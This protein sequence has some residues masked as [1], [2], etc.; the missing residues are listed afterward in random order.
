MINETIFIDKLCKSFTKDRPLLSNVTIK[1]HSGE[2]LGI[3]GPS[4]SGKSTLLRTI[5]GL[6]KVDSGKIFLDGNDITNIEVDKRGI[7]MVFQNFALF[8]HKNVYKNISFGLEIMNI[9][10]TEIKERVESLL[11]LVNLQDFEKREIHNLSG[12]E[13]QRVAIARSL[14]TTPKVLLMDEPFSALDNAVKIKLV[15]DIKRIVKKLKLSMIVVSHDQM[16]IQKLCDTSM[17]L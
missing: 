12:G 10:K 15:D 5:V 14:A 13:K 11:K 16:E 6:E 7:G 8:P 3:M 1:V 2:I 17:S 4:G 9:P